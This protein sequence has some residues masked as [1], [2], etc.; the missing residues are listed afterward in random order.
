M[1]RVRTLVVA[2]LACLVPLLVACPSDDG[3][4][5]LAACEDGACACV[6]SRECPS[7]LMCVDGACRGAATPPD[8]T[9]LPD[10][11][12]FD[13]GADVDDAS[14]EVEATGADGQA[15][16]API[17]PRG[18]GESCF[19][20][21]ECRSGH[22]V[23]SAAGGYCSRT[24]SPGCPEGYRCA[25]T[26]VGADPI[27]LCVVDESRLC[28]PCAD[29]ASCGAGGQDLCLAIG[30]GRFCSKGC[31]ST[32][33]PQGYACQT[34]SPVVG[35]TTRQ[36]IPLNGTCDCTAATAG[37]VKACTA[38][39]E[40]G[41]CFGLATCDPTSGFVDCSA[42]TPALELCNGRDDDC[43]GATDD[44]QEPTSCTRASELGTCSG[45]ETC[46]GAL[47]RVCNAKTPA[48]ESCNG[49]DDD[50]DGATDEDFR[51]GEDYTALAHCGACGHDCEAQFEHAAEV[52]CDVAGAAP[53]CRLV[54]CAPGYILL[55][56]TCIDE[57]A[58]L[59][60]PCNDD[61]DCYG[62]GSRCLGVSA[63]DPR[64]FCARDCSGEGE[65][66]S[67]CPAGYACEAV[68]GGR[69]Q[70]LPLTDS[71]DCTPTNVGQAKAC[72]R[73]SALGT[74]FGLE[75]CDAELGWQGCTAREPT[76][77]Q[78]NGED[79]DCDGEVD[80]A[81]AVG[82][83]CQI[84]NTFGTCS[85]LTVC[86][87]V[88]GVQCS[89]RTPTTETCNGQDDDCDGAIDDGFATMVD[90]QPKYDV[91]TAHCG[92]CGFACP[93]VAHGAVTCDG[94]GASPRCAI[95]SCDEGYYPIAGVVCA[96]VPATGSCALCSRDEDCAG[97]A[98]RCV[99]DGAGGG[100]CARDCAA[101][102]IYDTGE[103][104]CSGE[105][106]E[107][108]CCPDGFVCEAD[109]DARL[110]RPT[111]GTCDCV[112]DGATLAC[113]RES[114]F[115]RCFGTRTCELDGATPGLG[116]CTARV[117]SAELCNGEDDDCDGQIDASDPG[118]DATTTPNGQATCGDGPGCPG[119]WRCVGGAWECSAR[120]AS[121]EACDGADNDCD[122]AT[123]EDFRDAQ[124]RYVSV[125][126]CGACGLDCESLVA[127]ATAVTCALDGDQPTC[128]AT[129][130]APGTY[131]FD[132]GRA[133][134]AL[135]DNL[136]QAC[137]ADADCLVPG[138]R[139][140]GA[141]AERYCGRSCV[142]GSP[143]GTSCPT[144]WA[145]VGADPQCAPV[146]GSCACGPASVGLER[147]CAVGACTGLEQ[148]RQTGPDDYAFGPCSA[149]GLV[150]E[151]CDGADNDCDGGTDEGFRDAQG[152]YVSD[153]ACGA[154]GN[155]CTLR[156]PP[157]Q[158]AIGA[159]SGGA[160]PSCI[161]AACASELVAGTSYEWVDT[162]ALAGDGCECRRVAGNLADDPPDEDF[163][164][165]YPAAG[166]SY[167]DANCDGVDGV[168]AHAIFVSAANG[169]PGSGTRADPYRTIGQALAAF[170]GSGKQYILVAGG[171]YRESLSLTASGANVQLHGG[172][173]PD[174][175][176]RDIA[177]FETR[178]VG[179]E[180]AFG[181]GSVLPGAVYVA[182]ITSGRTLLSGFVV[183]GYDVTTAVAPGAQGYPSY[184]LYVVDANAS[185]EI[186]NCR[187]VGGLGGPGGDGAIGASGY[188]RDQG[189]AALDGKDGVSADAGQDCP[190]SPC[191]AGATRE[192]GAAGVNAQCGASGIDG[193]DA[194]CPVYDQAS[195]TPPVAGKDG[196]PGYHWTRDS[197]TNDGSCNGHL[198][199]AGF[200]DDI[201]KLDGLDGAA[202]TDGAE[203]IQGLGCGAATGSW[204]AG[205]WVNVAGA[206]GA[207]GV[208]GARGGAGAPSGGID[209]ATAGELRGGV[210]PDPVDRYRIG[211][212]GG[213]AGAGGCGGAG[214][215]GG[216][217][218]GASIAVFVTFV[219]TTPTSLPILRANLVERGLGG[220][221][222][223]GGFGGL[224]G[225]PGNGGRGGGSQDFWVGF[226]A[227]N[228][229]R[230]GFGGEGGGGGGGCGGAS[231]GIAVWRHPAALA[232]GYA[233]SNG[234]VLAEAQA[235][236]GSGGQPGPSGQTRPEGRG[237]N[238]ATVNLQVMPAP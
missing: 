150:P 217:S 101:G 192:G 130:C 81:V 36:C 108:G 232:V 140:L 129:A 57:N 64:T 214:G 229:G 56:A 153:R 3:E 155:D 161:I 235:T 66:T 60:S 183:R 156:W 110:C 170:P 99:A 109:G 71:C 67:A 103:R 47:G 197:A 187:L 123:D 233:A 35:P 63:T 178:I 182:G 122:G 38:E 209:T 193:G 16:G 136:C 177:A 87:G 207:G 218:G 25:Q 188:G 143:Y 157:E 234:F 9:A 53:T 125:D 24:C 200:P 74:C 222:G 28:R 33:C 49:Q 18:F 27:S 76:L 238:G 117:P 19:T 118:L 224:G 52:V 139:C 179:V 104:P 137:S 165:S 69:A 160:T 172:Y 45:T 152:V 133:C 220:D 176:R 132:G 92:A 12:V 131:A 175:A 95:A 65:T 89:A 198:T 32:P 181:Q 206:G 34:V 164:T 212:S 21:T 70:C 237:A 39:N 205:Q 127:N 116:A 7:P 159:C 167:V 120:P 166:A 114:A 58:T 78:C 46:Q 59:C 72:T 10:Q 145:C 42:E 173:A 189:G 105:P 100:R 62:D 82:D 61:G 5:T 180:P 185:L 11:I 79:D 213:G 151:V 195:W 168:A 191:G 202:G 216:G 128:L 41:T 20:S 115:G 141:G 221:G 2:A 226:R 225:S 90:G 138:S 158:H 196:A 50:C 83:A 204:S 88:L 54:A 77:E 211:A 73:T 107:V 106:G 126:H 208:A 171:D 1:T 154:C 40:A 93:P 6:Y 201:K 94:S 219:S 146:S 134:L 121:A 174:F 97:P 231:F 91:S 199:E 86:A 44:G 43:D 96:P 55:G 112:V 84:D 30:G 147:A 13:G 26:T 23:E 31:E 113:E 227:G 8:A 14:A 236:G 111:S 223:A 124:G 80:D 203:G 51:T 230:G 4:R 169:Q 15:D 37:L 144:G 48:A 184:A 190:L 194:V 228:G 68:A 98:D 119:A 22:C 162:N 75:T 85:G 215:A 163:G 148:C 210:Q 186:K 102:A 29:D 142:A 17:E 149:E 135:P